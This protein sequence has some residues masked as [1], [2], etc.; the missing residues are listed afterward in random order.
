MTVDK[1][2]KAPMPLLQ[3]P[4]LDPPEPAGGLVLVDG[5]TSVFEGPEMSDG[6]IVTGI[7]KEF[8]GG[9]RW[10]ILVTV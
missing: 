1:S 9:G 3:A 2:N 4:L 7:V 8:V 5:E 10:V 6:G